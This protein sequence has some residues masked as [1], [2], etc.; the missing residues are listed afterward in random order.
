MISDSIRPLVIMHIDAVCTASHDGHTRHDS[1]VT[2]DTMASLAAV[3][4]LA[5]V[6]PPSMAGVSMPIVE[7]TCLLY[8]SDGHSMCDIVDSY[9]DKQEGD[10]AVCASVYYVACR[11]I[12]GCGVARVIRVM[13]VQMGSADIGNATGLFKDAGVTPL[14]A[15]NSVQQIQAKIEFLERRY[16]DCKSGNFEYMMEYMKSSKGKSEYQIQ[17]FI[18]NEPDQASYRIGVALNP[19]KTTKM[20]TESAMY[21]DNGYLRYT[22]IDLQDL[23]NQY[24]KAKCNDKTSSNDHIHLDALIY[25]AKSDTEVQMLKTLPSS[26]LLS[27]SIES[28]EIFRNRSENVKFIEQLANSCNAMLPSDGIQIKVP[29]SFTWPKSSIHSQ[30][31]CVCKLGLGCQVCRVWH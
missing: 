20:I 23:S 2:A 15:V 8:V 19:K 9:M 29:S 11:P 26:I 12:D 31:V 18:P 22:A 27:N 7:Q 14:D 1:Y 16:R 6:V 13:P 30:S 3:C 28:V 24:D 10:A 4:R 21:I 25:K 5:I 17:K